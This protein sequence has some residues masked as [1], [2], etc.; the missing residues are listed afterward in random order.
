MRR[1]LMSLAALAL[2]GSFVGCARWKDRLPTV[3]KPLPPTFS[4]EL[5]NQQ[6][7][8]TPTPPLPPPQPTEPPVPPPKA[9]SVQIPD[10]PDGR[11]GENVPIPTTPI[12]QTGSIA[13]ADDPNGPTFVS[14]ADGEGPVRQRLEE[15]R[16]RREERREERQDRPTPDAKKPEAKAETPATP[17][18][19]K[20]VEESLKRYAD[21]ASFEARLVKR[22]VVNGK[23]MPQDEI[24]YHFRKA[25]LSVSMK[26][27]S[28]EGEGREVMYV[29]DQFGNKMHV[30]TG[31]GDNILVGAGYKTEVDPDSKTVT[32]KSRYRIYE[33]GFGRTLNGLTKALETTDGS[34]TVKALGAVNRKEF[35]YPLEA[36][37]VKIA[38]GQDPQLA[39]GGVRQVFFETKKDSPGYMLPVLVITTD[40][41]GK[42]VEYYFFD[43]L[44][45]PSSMT[46]EDWNPKSMGK[47]K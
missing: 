31:K 2:V 40:S 34:L 14:A 30:I 15:M 27:L 9:I 18:A 36:V 42:E 44:K 46:A 11:M 20:I 47:K 28:K 4:R 6:P 12:L 45:T 21:V 24:I 10:M 13:L 5:A 22:E 37:E 16:K 7:V 29:K 39:K 1:V 32:S 23:A 33:A 25:P 38:A 19:K 17:D 26:V 3:S 8:P 43:K 35:G 41:E